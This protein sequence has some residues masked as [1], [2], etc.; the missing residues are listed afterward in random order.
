M[1]FGERNAEGYYG[2]WEKK[3]RGTGSITQT[4]GRKEEG[5]LKFPNGAGVGLGGNWYRIS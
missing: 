2:Y 5:L 4:G 3:T 1:S